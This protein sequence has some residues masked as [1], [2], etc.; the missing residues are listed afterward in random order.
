M[1]AM[2]AL[3]HIAQNDSPT[4]STQSSSVSSPSTSTSTNQI[5]WSEDFKSFIDSCVTK[6]VSERPSAGQLLSHSFIATQS[7]RNALIELIK[8]TKE[9]VRDLDNLQYRKMKKIIMTESNSVLNS[10]LSTSGGEYDRNRRESG[11]RG[12]SIL[13]LKTDGSETSQNDTCSHLDDFEN[14][15]D[16]SSSLL[17]NT[18]STKFL[19]DNDIEIN[20]SM[21]GLNINQ[22]ESFS[23]KNT[24]NQAFKMTNSETL[25]SINSSESSSKIF[26]NHKKQASNGKFTIT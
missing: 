11:S 8:K 13:N 18:E 19:S 9:T 14:E 6:Q 15:Y 21:T 24:E 3:Y 17:D 20:E 5:A 7:D 16:E 2:S 22:N 23:K 10:S 12:S 1:N 26:S 4:L 25:S